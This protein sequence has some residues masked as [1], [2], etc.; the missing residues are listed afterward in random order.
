MML[1][2]EQIKIGDTIGWKAD[3]E[4]YGVLTEI[5]SPCL[6]LDVSDDHG[7]SRIIIVPSRYCW[8]E[9]SS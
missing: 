7:G 6:V 1:D 3:I 5:R 9:H 2:N 4:Q 8:L